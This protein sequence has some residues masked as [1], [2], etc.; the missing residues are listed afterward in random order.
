MSI[1]ESEVSSIKRPKWVWVIT[2]FYS[3]SFIFTGFSFFAIFSEIIPITEVE[4]AY[5]D[6]L[7]IFDWAMS[8]ISTLLNVV[9]VITLFLLKKITIKAWGLV[10]ICTGL[11]TIDA[12]IFT[13]Y[14]KVIEGSGLVGSLIG[15]IL[16]VGI[17]VYS[18]KLDKNGC[19]S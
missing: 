3:C 7:S 2:I 4:R 9:A 10:C 1:E 12:M 17:F 18:R 8:A 13:D 19:L 16:V 6:N 5:F 15:F 11:F 14:L